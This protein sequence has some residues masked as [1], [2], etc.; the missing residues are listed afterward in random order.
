MSPKASTKRDY[1]QIMSFT[2]GLIY[3]QK[4][5]ME[6]ATFRPYFS[7]EETSYQGNQKPPFKSS[8]KHNKQLNHQI[9]CI[10]SVCPQSH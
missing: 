8:P 9:S 1:E 4:L 5:S 10:S 3:L 2:F 7:C 6:I